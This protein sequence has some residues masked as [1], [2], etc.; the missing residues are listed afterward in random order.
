M[1]NSALT[2]TKTACS[3]PALELERSGQGWLLDCEIRRHSKPTLALRR[4]VLDNL[5]W[6]LRDREC[7]ACGTLE[8]RQFFV[9][10][11][12]EGHEE[13]RGR[14]GNPQQTKPVRPSTVQTYHRHLRTFFRFLVAEGVMEA[15]PMEA[16]PVPV[17]PPIRFSPSRAVRWTRA[18]PG[19][20]KIAAAAPKRSSPAVFLVD[21]ELRPGERSSRARQTEANRHQAGSCRRCISTGLKAGVRRRQE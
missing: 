17:A 19:R 1:K 8:L 16:V 11:S 3:L 9:Y 18:S 14:W 12:P 6:F 4:I 15:S 20:S 7:A 21:T 10:L 2:S 5:S 13:D